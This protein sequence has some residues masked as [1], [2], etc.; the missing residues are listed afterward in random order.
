MLLQLSSV[1]VGSIYLLFRWQVDHLT[2]WLWTKCHVTLMSGFLI[3][4][5]SMSQ[6]NTMSLHC[7]IP[8][9]SRSCK[10]LFYKFMY[11]Q[12]CYEYI[13]VS[14]M[15][16]LLENFNG[17]CVLYWKYGRVLELCHPVNIMCRKLSVRIK[18]TRSCQ[19]SIPL[20]KFE[21]GVGVVML[22]QQRQW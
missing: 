16:N 15:K 3:S 14:L 22:R 18:S 17:N 2:W 21:L 13:F 20:H 5:I 11:V 12:E 7:I 19:E 9:S 10:H 6:A 1:W 4:F 8:T